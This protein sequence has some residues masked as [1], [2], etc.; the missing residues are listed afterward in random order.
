MTYLTVNIRHKR[1]IIGKL[2]DD[3]QFRFGTVNGTFLEG[4]NYLQKQFGTAVGQWSCHPKDTKSN[5]RF[6]WKVT[7]PKNAKWN[8]QRNIDATIIVR[9]AYGN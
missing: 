2:A 1:D 6:A 5:F 9:I 7:L 8:G 4:L 3:E